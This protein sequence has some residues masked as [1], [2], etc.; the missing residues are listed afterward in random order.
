MASG[1]IE[2]LPGPKGR[3]KTAKKPA[4][5]HIVR[6]VIFLIILINKIK[7]EQEKTQKIQRLK[8]SPLSSEYRFNDLT[9]ILTQNLKRKIQIGQPT[10]PQT[11][12][13]AI[14]L[15]MA[16]DIKPNP[17]PQQRNHCIK[18]NKAVQE[19]TALHCETCKGWCHLQCNESVNTTI[20]SACSFDWVC[21]NPMCTPNHHSISIINP[22]TKPG[23]HQQN[24][25]EILQSEK[26]VKLPRSKK[27]KNRRSPKQ[28]KTPKKNKNQSK[29]ELSLLKSLPKISS[30]D[31]IGKEIC[32]SCHKKIGNTQK[33]ISCDC[34]NR[35]TH[36]ACSD[37][38]NATYRKKKNTIFPW[39]CN[40]CRTPEHTNLE[41]LD[42]KKLKPEEVP[43]DNETLLQY[44]KNKFLILH[45]NIRSIA[46]KAEEVYNIC[47]KLQPSILCLTETWLDASSGPNAYIP[48]GYNII[49]HDRSE[50][51]KQKYGKT[52]GGGV[53]ILYKKGLKIRKI[54]SGTDLEE[55][56]WL[57]VQG[58]PNFTVGIIYRA[59][60]TDLL[61]EKENG[62]PLEAQIN[63]A[64][65][66]NNRTIILGD[67][68]CDTEAIKPDTNTNVLLDVFDSQGMKQLIKKPTRIDQDNNKKTT[69]DHIWATSDEDFVRETGTVEGLS[70]HT[71]ICSDKHSKTK[72]RTRSV[73]IPRL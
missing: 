36:Q 13:L 27:L 53:A 72:T 4:C 15:I 32:R 12:H 20:I 44:S 60:Y 9:N 24:R 6:I 45:Y 3:R 33:A 2:T 37:M 56:L 48:E 10:N 35:W 46:N 14:L 7:R 41:I 49:R 40:T 16:G 59:S 31:Y 23:S 54:I 58:K 5:I 63:E 11:L 29:E 8:L 73:K 62:T 52:N 1:D 21:P 69:I 68:N 18:C 39:T 55:T 28:P 22:V 51:F 38:T 70:D 50:E 34:C 66:R 47:R 67:L 64:T 71:G 26:E 17:G 43:I 57:E 30:K 25:Y 19:E 42:T 61:T 65:S